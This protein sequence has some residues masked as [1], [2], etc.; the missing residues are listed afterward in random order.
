MVLQGDG[1]NEHSV[2]EP[3]KLGKECRISADAIMTG[4][5]GG[6]MQANID[7]DTCKFAFKAS[8]VIIDGVDV[9]IAK[10]PITD[11]GKRSKMGRMTL[12]RDYEGKLA[13]STTNDI[14]RSED[15]LRTVYEDGMLSNMESLA[16]I[17]ERLASQ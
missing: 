6:L 11:P 8:N 17:R 12:Y 2:V 1:I 7:R 4:S 13:T 9:P 14:V 5:G 15:L 16:T 10:D 3:Y